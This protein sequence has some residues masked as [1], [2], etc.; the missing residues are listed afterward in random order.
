M[1]IRAVPLAFDSM[2]VRSQ[3]TL[4]ETPDLRAV[5]DP[6]VA[7][8]PA[9]YGLPPHPLELRREEELRARV[10]EEARRSDLLV[11]SH[12]HHDHFDPFEPGLAEGKV[13]YLKHPT[14]ATNRSQRGRAAEFLKGL[15]KGPKK[16]EFADGR[17]FRHGGTSLT[18][19]PPVFHG[20]DDRLGYVVE[21]C[22]EHGG[23]RMVFASDVEGPPM[24]D[25]FD[26][27]LRS[28]PDLLLVDG[29]MTSMLGHRYS[30]EA[31]DASIAHLCRLVKE[32]EVETLIAD[33]HFLRDA[34]YAGHLDAVREVSR[35][36]GARVLTA[37]EFAGRPVEPL[38]ARRREL[39]RREPAEKRPYTRF[40]RRGS[41]TLSPRSAAAES[42]GG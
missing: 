2:G 9:R 27:M 23:E 10:F 4:V 30:R 39:Y 36:R 22:V 42:R 40:S 7:L 20:T 1:G 32:T 35:E 6:G 15:G 19:S 21:V 11:V 13:L 14:E 8:G 41:G 5:I 25:Q 17:S 16:I 29:P 38:E 28:R 37:A 34:G 18:F 3:A 12:Y 31:L 24:P 26:F 33:H